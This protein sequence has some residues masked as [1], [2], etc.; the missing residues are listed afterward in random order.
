[1]RRFVGSAAESKGQI[2]NPTEKTEAEKEIL[3]FGFF[4][5]GWTVSP[6]FAMID[7]SP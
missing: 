5:S 7:N 1:L 2:A 6:V 3:C 4:F